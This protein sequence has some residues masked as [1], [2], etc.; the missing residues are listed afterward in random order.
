MS[1]GLQSLY[2]LGVIL[3]FVVFAANFVELEFNFTVFTLNLV[4]R[5]GAAIVVLA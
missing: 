3:G 5:P 4:L 2:L 1:T